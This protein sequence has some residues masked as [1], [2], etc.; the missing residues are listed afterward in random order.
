MKL[1]FAALLFSASS[2]AQGVSL[3]WA[4]TPAGS[5]ITKFV[6][7]RSTAQHGPW[8]T[9]AEVGPSVLTYTDMSVSQN[10]YY[11]YYVLAYDNTLRVVASN[12][13]RCG[14]ATKNIGISCVSGAP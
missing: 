12:E 6:I 9:L 1:I 4:W 3:N 10:T 8:T 14:V 5:T 2:F 11:Y 13:I 7:A